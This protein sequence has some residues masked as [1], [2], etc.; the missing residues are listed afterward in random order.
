M[1][2][3]QPAWILLSSFISR[4]GFCYSVEMGQLIGAI[5]KSKKYGVLLPGGISL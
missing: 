5:M 1:Q 4:E 2:A 3:F